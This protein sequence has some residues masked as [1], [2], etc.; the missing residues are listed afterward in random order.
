MRRSI[1][2]FAGVT[3]LACV[4]SFA[5]IP[6]N[7]QDWLSPEKRCPSPYGA[8]DERGAANMQTSDSV[9]AAGKLIREGKI[10]ELGKVL[11]RNI[12]MSPGRSFVLSVQRTS[13]PNGRNQQGGNEE[14]VFTELGQMGTQFDGLAH[15]QLGRYLYNCVEADKVTR[16]SGFA[17][18][19]VEK[20]GSFFARGVLLDIA[21]LKGV[22]MLPD[23]YMIT[24]ADLEAGMKAA[25]VDIRKGDAVLIRTGWGRLWTVDNARFIKGEPGIGLEAADFLVKRN[26]M[27][28]GSDNWAVEVRPYPDKTLFLP[29]HGFLLNV[30]GV[31]LIENLDL[32]ALARDKATEFAFIVEPL[33]LRG[34]TGSSV[35][36]IAVR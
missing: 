19:G 24:V 36:P 7:A 30:N 33:K 2:R 23:D 29:V 25:N 5:S 16:R 6:A 26:V 35:A 21:G 13:G 28:V 20:A 22:D 34:A 12:P 31:Y 14:T 3:L 11:D 32:E 8:E 27:I 15:Q 17:K 18:L 4:A 9:L 10:Y 1:V